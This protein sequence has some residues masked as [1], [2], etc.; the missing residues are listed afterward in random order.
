MVIVSNYWV[1]I[2]LCVFAMVCWGSWSNTQKMVQKNWRFELFY[3]D[4]GIGI[5]FMSIFSAF[6][7]GSLGSEGREFAEDLS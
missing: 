1:A 3:W 4:S 2:L 5:L 6:S 7:V